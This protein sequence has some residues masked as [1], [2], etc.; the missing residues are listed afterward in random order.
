MTHRV[1]ILPVPNFQLLDMAGPLSVFQIAAE[2]V[3]GAYEVAVASAEG[4]LVRCSAGVPVLTR[5]WRG[6]RADTVLV[7]GGQGAREPQAAPA[8]LAYLRAAHARGRR[9]ASVCTGAFVLAQAGIL[10]GRRVTT[11]WRHAAELQQRHPALAVGITA[12]IDLALA[13]VQT[14]HG[15]AVARATAR[16]MVVYHRRTGGQSQFSALQDLAPASGRMR[17]V[18]A[19]VGQHL[20]EVLDIERLAGVACLSPRQF[21]RQFK[22]ETGQ[23]PAKAV[24]RVRAEAARELVEE[25]EAGMD[26]IAR[27][28]G[29]GDTERMRRAFIRI[30]GQPPQALRRGAPA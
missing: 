1:C 11:H 29:F 18:L 28:V 14:D 9:V 4:G 12:G 20:D 10:Q 6:L 22:L 2:L 25:G 16:E 27:R 19:H 17:E 26:A 13:M 23:T 5:P 15:E 7:P 24:E 30:Y 3:P 21:C 8:M